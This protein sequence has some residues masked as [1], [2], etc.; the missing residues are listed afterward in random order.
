MRLQLL[1]ASALGF[2]LAPGTVQAQTEEI[3]REIETKLW[4]LRIL[5]RI[6]AATGAPP[7]VSLLTLLTLILALVA[8]VWLALRRKRTDSSPPSS[9]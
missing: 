8:A 5:A 4:I 1:L 2:L 9:S 7:V 3:Q 6:E